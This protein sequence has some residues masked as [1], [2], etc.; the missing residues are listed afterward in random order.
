M[1]IISVNVYK[2]IFNKTMKIYVNSVAINVMSVKIHHK[3]VLLVKV[4]TELK[5]PLN[6]C[7]KQDIMIMDKI[8]IVCVK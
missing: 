1:Q 6:A 2:V 3:T 8:K 7:V 4:K 5:F